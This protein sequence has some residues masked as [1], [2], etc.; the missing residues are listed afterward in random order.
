[1][2]LCTAS[3][4]VHLGIRNAVGPLPGAVGH[5]IVTVNSAVTDSSVRVLLSKCTSGGDKDAGASLKDLEHSRADFVSVLQLLVEPLRYA[6][7]KRMEDLFEGSTPTRHGL[8][9][10]HRYG[11]ASFPSMG[12]LPRLDPAFE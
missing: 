8:C 10:R 4:L 7:V 3:H 1:M 2:I 5:L 9:A 12:V 6:A 11:E